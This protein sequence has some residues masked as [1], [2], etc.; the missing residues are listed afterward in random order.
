MFKDTLDGIAILKTL[1][2]FWNNPSAKFPFNNRG[3]IDAGDWK[4][5]LDEDIKA[6][7]VLEKYGS[8][9]D[10]V[11]A[12]V[13]AQK[14]IG[15][16]KLILPPQ[17]ATDDDWNEVYNRLGR[18]E[19]ADG[20]KRPEDV[21]LPEGMNI[22]EELFKGFAEV[23][24]K[25]GLLPKQVE[26]LYR[27]YMDTSINHF[28]NSNQAT[29]DA[30]KL[31]ETNLRKQWGVAYESKVALAKKALQTIGD[32]ESKALLAEGLGNDP[33]IVRMFAKVGE[34]LSEDQLTGKPKGLTMTPDEALVE[35]DK[36]KGDLEGPYF[37]PTNPLHDETVKK[38]A[39]LYRM[40]YPE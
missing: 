5:D 31:A 8:K 7:P 32:D 16:D 13:E 18:P 36:I 11:K 39:D 33:R 38:T 2:K 10:A 37:D 1:K 9:N 29:T 14:L 20:Y 22:D 30:T 15:R 34:M 27:W 21:Q 26:G 3:E 4:T 23:A 28:N 35:I 25:S 19:G 17:D 12:L 24:H 6:H 40:A